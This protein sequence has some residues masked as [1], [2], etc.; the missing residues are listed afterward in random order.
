MSAILSRDPP[1]QGSK[2]RQEI[3]APQRLIASNPW[4][5]D[6]SVRPRKGPGKGPVPGK[7]TAARCLAWPTHLKEK[8]ISFRSGE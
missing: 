5:G 7:G 3:P 6:C 4:V 8:G 1:S 2:L